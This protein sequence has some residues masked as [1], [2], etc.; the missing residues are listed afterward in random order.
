MSHHVV[1]HV[2]WQVVR[3][4]VIHEV[5][6]KAESL[7]VK[8]G[9]SIQY[10]CY[11]NGVMYDEYTSPYEPH[12]QVT[13]PKGTYYRYVSV[14][15]QEDRQVLLALFFLP[16]VEQLDLMYDYR[17]GNFSAFEPYFMLLAADPLQR[18]STSP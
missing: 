16:G 17:P 11:H 12:V 3:P 14:L 18:S 15:G 2:G 7:L 8:S 4:C 1:E 9:G 13:F 6:Q 10:R 5:D